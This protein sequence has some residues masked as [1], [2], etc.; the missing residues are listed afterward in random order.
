[1][2]DSYTD[3]YQFD[4]NNEDY[5]DDT[6]HGTQFKISESFEE[7]TDKL[8][9][10]MKTGLISNILATT[11][12]NL[13]KNH[14]KGETFSVDKNDNSLTFYHSLDDNPND[15]DRI[16]LYEGCIE[17]IYSR[18]DILDHNNSVLESITVTPNKKGGC[19]VKGDCDLLTDFKYLNIFDGV[20]NEMTYIPHSLINSETKEKLDDDKLLKVKKDSIII[21][22]KI[23]A[24]KERLN[25]IRN[26]SIRTGIAMSKERGYTHMSEDE[27]LQLIATKKLQNR[28]WK[29]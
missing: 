13:E 22:E 24:T 1:M 25:N 6:E 15:F 11:I 28:N 9:K 10:S 8:K 18:E 14:Y 23:G 5:I 7:L 26:N 16:S 3:L 4:E 2:T 12:N 19:T 29:E 27:R 20:R 17:L 21:Q